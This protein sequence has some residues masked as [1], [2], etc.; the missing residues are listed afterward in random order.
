MCNDTFHSSYLKLPFSPGDPTWQSAAQVVTLQSFA[1]NVGPAVPVAASILEIFRLFFTRALMSTVIL[2]TNLYAQQVLGEKS[3]D[4]W[5][6]VTESDILAFLGFAILM[7]I[8]QL[9]SLADYWKKDP[10]FH[11]SPIADRITRD[12]FLE[13]WKYLH[14]VDNSDLPNRSDPEYDRLCRVR[15]VIDSVLEACKVNYS[16][17]QHQSIDEAMIAFKGRNS[18]KQYMPK[19]PTKRGFKVWVRAGSTNGYVSQFEFY[20][21]KQGSNV[22]VRLGAT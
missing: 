3:I 9:P 7:G 10:Y 1:E 19:K 20:T 12:R 11:Y 17:H 8:N 5:T 14:F 13:I 16:P 21:G 18:M 6:D 22:E 2:Q 4:S 15:P